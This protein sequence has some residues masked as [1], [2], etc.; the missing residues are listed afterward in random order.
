MSWQES[1]QNGIIIRTGDGKEWRPLYRYNS[2]V[3]EF[4]VSEFDFPNIDGTKVDRR[5]ARGRKFELDIIFQ[6][7]D[8]LDVSQSF[9]NSSKDK[10]PWVVIHP[11]FGTI[12]C[13]PASLTFDPSGINTTVITGSLLETILNDAPRI[14]TDPA[15]KITKDVAIFNELSALSF[16]STELSPSDLNLLSNNTSEIAKKTSISMKIGDNAQE[17]LNES[18]SVLSEI[19]GYSGN[20]V[21]VISSVKKVILYPSQFN[22]TVQN[23]IAL[24]SSQLQSLALTVA[25]AVTP[26]QKKIYEQGS[27]SLLS[28]ILVSAAT[29]IAGDYGNVTD[30]LG[31]ISVITSSYNGVISNLDMLQTLNGGDIESYIPDAES[32]GQL[33][34]VTN[35]TI[36]QLLGIALNAKQERIIICEDDTDIITLTHRF[37]GITENDS[38]IN[39]L[40]ANNQIGLN[41][42]LMIRKG[43]KIKYYV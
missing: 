19:S 11:Q 36:S 42:M 16:S 30:V 23:R 28:G 12:N 22:D 4:N 35:Y 26:N 24:L 25:G 31:V 33:T 32:I 40:I 17:F 5:E 3:L 43:R 14:S 1:I 9:E 10:R 15:G 8:H 7:E 18:R 37:Y 27:T 38:T 20:A 39:D 2:K 21:S 41:E 13:H 6:G 34:D 29:P